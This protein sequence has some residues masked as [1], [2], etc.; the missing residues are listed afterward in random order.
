MISNKVGRG[1]RFF[2][3]L[4][5]WTAGSLSVE[6]GW[7]KRASIPGRSRRTVRTITGGI[8]STV[9]SRK[10]CIC[11]A[12]TGHRSITGSSAYVSDALKRPLKWDAKNENIIGDAEAD[13]LL[14]VRL[15]RRLVAWV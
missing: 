2:S 12:E 1:V 3:E 10:Q 13:K 14:N 7:T 8:L 9:K 15:P 4:G 6:L 11:P 5:V